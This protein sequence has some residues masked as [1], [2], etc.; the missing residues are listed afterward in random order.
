MPG[1]RAVDHIHIY[2]GK[3]H[4]DPNTPFDPNAPHPDDVPPDFEP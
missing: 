1:W 3:E 2:G 4:L